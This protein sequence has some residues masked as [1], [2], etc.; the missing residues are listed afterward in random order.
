MAHNF[1]WRLRIHHHFAPSACSCFAASHESLL[2]SLTS[3][4]TGY[5]HVSKAFEMPKCSE[6]Y[7]AAEAD[8][9]PQLRFALNAL[10]PVRT[11]PEHPALECDDSLLSPLAQR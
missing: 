10:I 6:V 2:V 9:T 8:P 5:P 3:P 11:T 7:R 1:F 4:Y